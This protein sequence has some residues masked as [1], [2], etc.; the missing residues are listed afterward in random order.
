MPAT[1]TSGL[2]I[3]LTS[4]TPFNILMFEVY[5]DRRHVSQENFLLFTYSLCIT[6]TRRAVPLLFLN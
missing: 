3:P 2:N 6:K 5:S 4:H 1:V